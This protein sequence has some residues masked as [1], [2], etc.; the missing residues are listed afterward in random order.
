[1]EVG[2]ANSDVHWGEYTY[3]GHEM[4]LYKPETVMERA[5]GKTIVSKCFLT[6]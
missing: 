5:K 1:M 6:I 4:F 3:L 2:A